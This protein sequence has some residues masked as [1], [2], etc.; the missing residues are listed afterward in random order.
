MQAGSRERIHHAN[1]HPP[2]K[3]SGNTDEASSLVWQN[4]P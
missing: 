4:F 2:Y 1:A 3:D